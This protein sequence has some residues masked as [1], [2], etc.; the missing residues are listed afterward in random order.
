VSSLSTTVSSHTTS[1]STLQ[2][3]VSALQSAVSSLQS[4]VS[5]LQTAAYTRVTD[6]TPTAIGSAPAWVPILT[7]TI[8]PGTSRVLDGYIHLTGGSASAPTTGIIAFGGVSS[9]TARRG[10]GGGAPTLSGTPSVVGGTIAALAAQV[11]VVGNDVV[12]QARATGG[13]P[14]AKTF[15]YRWDADTP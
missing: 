13:P 12:V 14:V 3:D 2:S 6:D 15:F 11:I 8:A 9:I 5:T 10:S 1:I 4:T 7:L